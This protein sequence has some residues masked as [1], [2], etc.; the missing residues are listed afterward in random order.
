MNI[1]VLVG[2]YNYL[3]SV[4]IKNTQILLLAIEHILAKFQI[5]H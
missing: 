4:Y 2:L 5:T 1:L 3:L